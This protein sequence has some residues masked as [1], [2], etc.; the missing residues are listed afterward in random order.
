MKFPL[1]VLT[2]VEWNTIQNQKILSNNV[3][4]PNNRVAKLA[5]FAITSTNSLLH[6][7]KR[8]KDW[9]TRY[10]NDIVISW[11]FQ[12]S[13][14]GYTILASITRE[15]RFKWC[16]PKSSLSFFLA[17]FFGAF[18]RFSGVF[19]LAPWKIVHAKC[20][21]KKMKNVERMKHVERKFFGV[22]SERRWKI[23]SFSDLHTVGL[24]GL[25]FT[26]W[27]FC[28]L[29]AMGFYMGLVEF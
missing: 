22:T 1:F 6:C 25:E 4:A 17:Y 19:A 23:Q 14:S 5:L 27:S 18:S 24:S 11:T 13:K 29:S 16:R 26:C 2:C 10:L 20:T 21:C 7:S 28:C 3:G 8:L 15:L 12:P 9:V